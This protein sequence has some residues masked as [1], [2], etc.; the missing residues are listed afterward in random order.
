MTKQEQQYIKWFL[1]GKEAK[2]NGWAKISPFYENLTAEYFFN[3]GYDGQEFEECK[4]FM[5]EK[6]K[7]LL[8]SSPDLV[9]TVNEFVE[10]LAKV[11]QEPE[12]NLVKS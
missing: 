2:R 4:Q 8:E 11:L 3:C 7:E 12:V 6:I 9:K 5:L 1:T 10:P